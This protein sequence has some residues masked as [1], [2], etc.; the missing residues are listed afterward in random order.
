MSSSET[1]TATDA[2]PDYEPIPESS[3]GPALNDQGYA[4]GRVERN[5]YW[6]TDGVYQSAFLTTLDGV[7]LFDTPPRSAT[8][9][10]GP[11]TRSPLPTACPTRSR[12]SSTPITT[13]DHASASSLFENV[14]R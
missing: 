1:R 4:V 13:P 11:W 6:V 9:C 7:V 3:F 2:L 5:P 14:V 10:G 12:T 8:T